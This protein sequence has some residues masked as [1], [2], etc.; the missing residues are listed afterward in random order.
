[1][2]SQTTQNT[3]ANVADESAIRNIPMRMIEAWNKG[4]GEAFAEKFTD[5]ADF[6]AFEGTHLKGRQE[7]AAFH[8]RIFDTAMKGSKLE[9]DVIFVRFLSPQLAIMHSVAMTTLS[10]QT[11]SSPGRDSIQIFVVVKSNEGW[12]V[13]GLLNARKLTI[14]RQLFLDDFD[15]LVTK[16]QRQVIDFTAALRQR[17][18]SK[19]AKSP[20]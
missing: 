18:I 20:G 2:V 9:G 14:E 10:G 1:M 12:R 17:Q 6:I 16:D 4:S 11:S 7:I 13:E 15:S 8:Q 5:T 3:T 19:S